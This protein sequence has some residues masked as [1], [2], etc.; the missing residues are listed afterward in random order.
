MCSYIENFFSEAK[1]VILSPTLFYS[2]LNICSKFSVILAG[3]RNKEKRMT[4]ERGKKNEK[5]KCRGRFFR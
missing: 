3:W 1:D 4:A 2:S 5:E